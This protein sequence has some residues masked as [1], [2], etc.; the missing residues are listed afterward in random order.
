MDKIS[1]V[2]SFFSKSGA[3]ECAILCTFGLNLHFFEN[4][5]LK[6]NA[7]YYCDNICIFTDYSVYNNFLNENY[8]QHPRWLNKKYLVSPLKTNGFFH[9]K[10]YIIAS[11][12]K[13]LIG[14]GSANLTRDGIA[15]NLE[16]VSVFEVLKD[17][18]TYARV[19]QSSI[20]YVGRLAVLS[21]SRKAIEQANLLK[22]IC[23]P[24]YKN[25]SP[26]EIELIHNLDIPLLEQIKEKFQNNKIHKIHVISP[27]FD[28][29]LAPLEK[30]LNFFPNSSVDIYVQQS[31]SNFPLHRF[32]NLGK[33]VNLRLYKNTDR[34]LHGK[35]L[36]FES[37]D[38]IFMYCG[39]ANFTKSALL[40]L[41]REG[42]FEVGL[43]GSIDDKVFNNIINPHGQ[44]SGLIKDKSD[45]KVEVKTESS[46][47]KFGQLINFIIEAEKIE[48]RIVLSVN[49]EITREEFSPQKYRLIDFNGAEI[50]IDIKDEFTII[51]D[52]I[53]KKKIESIDG[54]QII[55][56]DKDKKT[57]N[58]NIVWVIDLEKRKTR[59]QVRFRKI[60]NN[61]FELCSILEEMMN[62]DDIEGFV[63]FIYAF[64]IPLDL[65]LPP[66]IYSP[67]ER[68][69]KGNVEGRLPL[70]RYR[71]LFQGESIIKLY[72]YFLDTLY[73]KLERHKQNPQINKLSNFVLIISTLFSFIDFVNRS[74]QGAYANKDTVTSED[75]AI[76][77]DQYNLIFEYVDKCWGLI[78]NK[79]GYKELFN[80]IIQRD[81]DRDV[82]D[83]IMNFEDYLVKNDYQSQ[84]EDLLKISKKVFTDF[85]LLGRS[86]NIKTEIGTIVPAHLFP[87]DIYLLNEKEIYDFVLKTE[88]SLNNYFIEIREESET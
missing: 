8:R 85:S 52:A 24:F 40:S 28:D 45:L 69:S 76:I 42:N 18:L 34:Y 57:K 7:L 61:P 14:I 15:S 1:L 58:S 46:N 9:S 11:E 41:S 22:D 36:I 74:I 16:L 80:E 21:K 10:L 55:G 63:K 35:S 13:V 60:Y 67:K 84:I 25:G 73:N 47:E 48:N 30:I 44:K 43:I 72:Q 6:Q 38:K 49:E 26:G 51:V 70:H 68:E 29:K 4:Y 50:E 5:L 75:W 78:F 27:F 32:D 64:D 33:D 71:S 79:D 65:I 3:F 31:R 23:I 59:E 56:L 19:L 39:S 81:Q 62:A 87:G 54:I 86:V 83:S 53:Q 82:D 88:S 20:D 17:D 2:D 12:K 37:K 66:R 77:R